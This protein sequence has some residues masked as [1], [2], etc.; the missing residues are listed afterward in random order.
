VTFTGAILLDIYEELDGHLEA[1]IKLANTAGNRT[2]VASDEE[3]RI[4]YS[5]STMMEGLLQGID[6][7][8][9]W[10]TCIVYNA[11]FSKMQEKEITGTYEGIAAN[12]ILGDICTAAGVTAGSCPST[13]ISVRFNKTECFEA[14]VYIA[15]CCNNNYWPSGGTATPT[16]NI[17]ARG[18]AKGTVTDFSVSNRGIDRAKKRDKVYVRG[19]DADGL[20]II[21]VAGAGTRVRTFTEKK[22]ADVATLNNI[23]AKKLAELNTDTSQVTITATI[24]DGYTVFPGDTV[25]LDKDELALP[26]GSY[27]VYDIRKNYT[28]VEFSVD[29]RKKTGDEEL[30]DLARLEDLG[31]YPIGTGQGLPGGISAAE[32]VLLMHFNEGSGTL[33]IDSSPYMNDG[34]SVN[35]TYVTGKF[36][37][38]LSFAGNGYVEI[39][40]DVS[41]TP[42]DNLSF[43]VWFKVD[44]VTAGNREIA[45]K[46]DV[47]ALRQN[48]TT[49][50][51]LIYDGTDYAP[52]CSF[53]PLVVD[54]WYHAVG[55]WDQADGKQR[56]YINAVLEDEITHT[57]NPSTGTNMYIGSW[58][59]SEY[60]VG[61]IEEVRMY[62][63]TL[64]PEE[65]RSLYLF[66]G[67]AD[68]PP[69]LDVGPPVGFDSADIST[70]SSVD[71][72]G[73]VRVWFNVVVPR[74]EYA[75]SY[76]LAYR[77]TG[78][79]D[80]TE[81]PVEQPTTGSPVVRTPFVKENIMYYF[82]I[83]SLNRFGRRTAWT[84]EVNKNSTYKTTPPTTPTGLGGT[85][86]L[87]GVLLEWTE[88]DDADLSHYE[89][90]INTVND[91][92]SATRIASIRTNYYIWHIEDSANDYTIRYFWVKAVDTSG[93]ISAR[94]ISQFAAE[95]SSMLEEYDT[96]ATVIYCDTQIKNTETLAT[97]T[98]G[99]L[100]WADEAQTGD[101]TID[102]AD[103]SQRTV[104]KNTTGTQFAAGHR[105]FYWDD[106]TNSL[107]NTTDYGTAVGEGK[108]LMFVTNI[109]TTG[110]TT[111]LPMSSYAP[112]IGVGALAATTIL[113]SHLQ[114]GVAI[115]TE[116]AQIGNSLIINDHVVS[117]QSPKIVID[118]TTYLSNWR[119]GSGLTKIDGGQIYTQSIVSDSIT[120]TQ[121]IEGKKYRTATSGGR[122]EFDSTPQF[123]AYNSSGNEILRMDEL[124][125]KLAGNI[126][127]F[128]RT[129]M[130]TL[131][132]AIYAGE[133]DDHLWIDLPGLNAQLRLTGGGLTTAGDILTSLGGTHDIGKVGAKFNDIWGKFHYTDFYMSDMDCC[134]CGEPFKLHDEF[135]FV[136]QELIDYKLEKNWRSL[137]AHRRCPSWLSR[138]YTWLLKT[139]KLRKNN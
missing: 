81:I 129:D 110:P 56:L 118:G 66:G 52:S 136:T 5:A 139:L 132:G 47:F 50:T 90:Y 105:Y 96:T 91:S 24:A 112:T 121:W 137:P 17:G 22:A 60:F 46:E 130:A 35:A 41:I 65:I 89:V 124:G 43:S 3:V 84:S 73:T 97:P 39:T 64:S 71:E 82:R 53:S 13:L 61:D 63:R 95:I 125:I 120:A 113:S 106:G 135:V 100:Y 10:L 59:A 111:I 4:Q 14:A 1:G 88:I 30:D 75:V 31:I 36:G 11:C 69:E 72:D 68:A 78:T 93:S 57:Y 16:F 116:S 92:G 20:E 49:L 9:D 58:G 107:L 18:S 8:Q 23:A 103:G 7:S 134:K 48:G 2:I 34:T 98:Y 127:S 45:G 131:R 28:Q 21:G 62:G 70:A 51:W 44:N 85:G 122:I 54:T 77:E 94:L 87:S 26:S 29:R 119:H 32:L 138:G 123:S 128:Y 126:M 38:A 12:T 74:V 79:T 33:Q 40:D 115:I 6:Y 15:D 99:K 80:W 55:L 101:G 67:A 117:V 114:T 104:T 25:T 86:I 109:S 19:V 83:C 37:Y 76:I 42:P 108:G 27:K 102:F 133:T